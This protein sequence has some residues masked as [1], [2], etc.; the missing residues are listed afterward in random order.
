MATEAVRRG[1]CRDQVGLRWPAV[2]R[3]QSTPLAAHTNVSVA[4]A[5][6]CIA[7]ENDPS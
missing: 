4:S 7:V 2:A 1:S 6:L 5:Y 3:W